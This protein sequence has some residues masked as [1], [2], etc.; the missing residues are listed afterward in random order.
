MNALFPVFPLNDL[1]TTVSGLVSGGEVTTRPIFGGG[2]MT[3]I[4]PNSGSPVGPSP[5]NVGQETS[6]FTQ[7]LVR[8][9]QTV[10]TQMPGSDGAKGAPTPAAG[11]SLAV[12]GFHDNQLTRQSEAPGLVQNVSRTV[13]SVDV[14]T[15]SLTQQLKSS[16]SIG[17]ELA[18]DGVGHMSNMLDRLSDTS[19]EIKEAMGRNDRPTVEEET[20][21]LSSELSGLSNLLAQIG[22]AAQVSKSSGAVSINI[23][24]SGG[25]Y[26][27]QIAMSRMTDDVDPRLTVQDTDSLDDGLVAVGKMLGDINEL[28]DSVMGYFTGSASQGQAADRE[29]GSLMDRKDQDLKAALQAGA[30]MQKEH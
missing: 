30:P 4:D 10:G 29:G 16:G 5:D 20:A 1:G 15:T 13:R 24:L 14:Q 9:S 2:K 22:Q 26:G 8:A 3:K 19:A 23:N 25:H 11:G 17:Q 7:A 6:A 27:L 12:N 28:M 18:S 21:M